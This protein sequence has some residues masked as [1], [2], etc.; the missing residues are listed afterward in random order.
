MIFCP[1]NCF[2][3]PQ[4]KRSDNYATMFAILAIFLFAILSVWAD[5][6]DDI[7]IA[8]PTQGQRFSA[9]DPIAVV[10]V[11]EVGYSG[12]ISIG[13]GL[14]I[15]GS[16]LSPRTMVGDARDDGI[17][18][19]APTGIPS[20]GAHETGVMH[21]YVY[22]TNTIESNIVADGTLINSLV[23][24]GEGPS[25]PPTVVITPISALTSTTTEIVT[26][27]DTEAETESATVNDTPSSTSVGTHISMDESE[28]TESGH[29]N[30]AATDEATSDVYRLSEADGNGGLSTGAK[31]GISAAVAVGTVL[32]VALVA[33]FYRRHKIESPPKT[34]REISGGPLQQDI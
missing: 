21:I 5:F 20:I 12:P 33:F 16:L 32:L 28:M 6:T 14:S 30:P 15:Q 31:A 22:T 17:L 29:L 34:I 8:E 18:I 9:G 23:I 19:Y 25:T 13:V 7:H 10:W 27:A 26:T 2:S 11:N 1:A 4:F 3:S 24:T